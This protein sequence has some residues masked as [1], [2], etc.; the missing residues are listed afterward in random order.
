MPKIWQE[1]RD[2]LSCIHATDRK[3]RC[4]GSNRSRQLVFQA[5]C[6]TPLW[7]HAPHVLIYSRKISQTVGVLIPLPLIPNLLHRHRSTLAFYL[8]VAGVEGFEPPTIGFGD[9]CSTNWNYTPK[10]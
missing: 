1:S 4:R 8:F 3:R 5:S 7:G 9:R 10:T 6:L 2:D